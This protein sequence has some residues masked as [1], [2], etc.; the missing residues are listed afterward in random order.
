VR[1]GDVCRKFVQ[2]SKDALDL[3]GRLIQQDQRE[4]QE[5]LRTRFQDM[6][7]RLADIF[8]EPVGVV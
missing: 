3:N 6:V 5:S 1:V 8:K 4:Y 2:Y 7:D